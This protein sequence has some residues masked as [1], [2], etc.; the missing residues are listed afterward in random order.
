MALLGKNLCCVCSYIAYMKGDFFKVKSTFLPSENMR[1]VP[2][3]HSTYR[4]LE[5]EV[6][7]KVKFKASHFYG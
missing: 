5:C 2:N 3:K 7:F 6:L 1:E 4:D